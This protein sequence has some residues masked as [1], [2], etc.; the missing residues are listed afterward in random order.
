MTAS[1]RAHGIVLPIREDVDGDEVGR[2][3]KLGRLEPELPDIGI[4]DGKSRA[5]L[6]LREIGP[7]RRGSELAPEQRLIADDESLDRP[8]M[9]TGELQ[10]RFDLPAIVGA[11]P[12][13]PDAL[14]HLEA[15]GLGKPRDPSLRA[16]GRIGP[17]ARGEG[18]ESP[19]ILGDLP[20][21][22]RRFQVKGAWSSWNGA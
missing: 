1:V 21:G 18:R 3:G 6:D 17:D 11:V 19:Q 13:E 15:L 22:M 2:R 16:L 8:G 9:A 7:D 5:P 12:T 20:S 10:R 4:G 14:Q